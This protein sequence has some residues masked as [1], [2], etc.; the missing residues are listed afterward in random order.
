MEG[1]PVRPDSF[2]FG[3]KDCD[4]TL[5][6]V[7]AEIDRLQAEHPDEVICMDGTAYAVVGIPKE[8]YI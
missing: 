5:A 7:I 1:C 4:M 6:Q 8:V 2:Y 3:I